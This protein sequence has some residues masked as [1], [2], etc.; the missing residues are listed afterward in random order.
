MFTFLPCGL[1]PKSTSKNVD[2]VSFKFTVKKSAWFKLIEA[3]LDV[4][5]G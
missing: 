3:V 5:D 4:I 2:D 1:N